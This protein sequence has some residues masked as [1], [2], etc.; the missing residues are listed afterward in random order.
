MITLDLH[1]TETQ[2]HIETL[3]CCF[4]NFHITARLRPLVTGLYGRGRD[5]RYYVLAGVRPLQ[6]VSVDQ[7]QS[8]TNVRY[9]LLRYYSLPIVD[10]HD[11]R[12]HCYLCASDFNYSI[13]Q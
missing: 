3:V 10:D 11:R 2:L 13:A 1:V 5:D 7:P 9:I 12:D 8:G 6:T 4:H